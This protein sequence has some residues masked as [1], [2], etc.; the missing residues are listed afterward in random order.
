MPFLRK[1]NTLTVTGTTAIRIPIIKRAVVDFA[2][3]ADW[4]PAAGDVKI[5][6]DGAAAANVTNLPTA[7]A[8]GNGAY[9]EFILTAAELSCKSCVVTV[10]DSATKA[11]E[12]Q[13]FIV[14]TYGHASAMY[15]ADLSAANLPANVTQLLGTAWLTPGTPGTPDVNVK[16]I[17]GTSQ[18]GRD[19][20]ASVLLSSGTGTGQLKLASG[21]VAMTWADIAAPTTTVNLSGTTVKTATDVETDTADIQSR[22]PASLTANGNMKSSLM[23][24]IATALTETSGLLAAGFKKFFNV[25]TP[26]GTVNSLPDAVPGNSS[27][28]PRVSD[29]PTTAQMEAAILNEGDATALLAAIA[30]KVEAFLINEGDATATIAAIATACNAAVA[31]GAVGA[32]AAAAAT[33][34]AAGAIRTAIGLA[35]ANL[36]T[37]LDAVPTNADLVT[38]LGTADDATLAAIA[39]EAVKTAAIKAKT[40]QMVFTTANRVDASATVSIAAADIR[41][42]LGMA[43]AD[44]DDQLDAILAAASASAGSGARTVTITVN[45]GATAIQNAVVR[46]TDGATSYRTLT[47]VSGVAVFNVD[48][49]TYTVSITKLGYTYAGTTLVVNGTETATYSM[50]LVVVTPPVNPALSAIEVL[51]LG[52]DFEAISSIWFMVLPLCLFSISRQ[53]VHPH[54]PLHI[55][56][57][58]FLQFPLKVFV[59]DLCRFGPD[60]LIHAIAPNR[61]LTHPVVDSLA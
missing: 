13:A 61:C 37:Q 44:L 30:A 10:A 18:T 41:A 28:L 6:I 58:R 43:A 33:Q 46:L 60:M 24:I 11:V 39:A 36:D 42:A 22:L 56:R 12:D 59:A 16:L 17:G 55:P 21:Y 54:L 20:G 3:S 15:Q 4:T 25:A 49:A 38:A 40:D 8:M 47:N 50:T 51:C 7:V 19:I 52:A 2:V 5:A 1:Y 57:L 45:D 34:T 32:N 48:D 27:G 31:A 35:S 23:E 29:V 14:E 9:W 26:T 53:R